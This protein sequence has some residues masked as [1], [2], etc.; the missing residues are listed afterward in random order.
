MAG[1]TK[2]RRNAGKTR[3]RR[4]AKEFLSFFCRNILQN[5]PFFSIIKICVVLSVCTG[6]EGWYSRLF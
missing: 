5:R 4:G 6:K 2:L 3:S 1:Y